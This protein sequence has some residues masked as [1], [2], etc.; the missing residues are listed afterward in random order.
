MH[1][2]LLMRFQ[3][4]IMDT[5]CGT[6]GYPLRLETLIWQLA[7]GKSATLQ[8]CLLWSYTVIGNT[9]HELISIAWL[10]QFSL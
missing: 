3:K 5:M 8:P 2:S 7:P 6:L 10:L 9:V 1:T 4:F